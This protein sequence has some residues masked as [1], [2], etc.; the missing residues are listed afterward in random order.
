MSVLSEQKSRILLPSA[1]QFKQQGSFAGILSS[2]NIFGIEKELFTLWMNPLR[3]GPFEIFWAV[4]QDR[5]LLAR[6]Q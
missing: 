4:I 5:K 6:R 2:F 3:H 1:A